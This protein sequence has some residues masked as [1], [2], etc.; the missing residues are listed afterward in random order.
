MKLRLA[1]TCYLAQAGFELSILLPQTPEFS[2]YRNALSLPAKIFK[3]CQYLWNPLTLLIYAN[4]KT[5]LNLKKQL[6]Y[7]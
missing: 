4:A 3:S 1:S 5:K 2:D 6:I 7:P